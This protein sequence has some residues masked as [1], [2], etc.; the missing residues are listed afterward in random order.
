MRKIATAACALLVLAGA[1]G[2]QGSFGDTLRQARLQLDIGNPREAAELYERAVGMRSASAQ[3]LAPERAWAYVVLGNEALRGGDYS[4]AEAAYGMAAAVHEPFT[5]VFLRQWVYATLRRV[6]DEISRAVNDGAS[7][8]WESL[9]SSLKW[10]LRKVPSDRYA[11][12]TL[13]VLYDLTRRYDEARRHYGLLL[14]K[15]PGPD[16]ALEDLRRRARNRVSG[17]RHSFDMRPI[18]PPWRR[19]SSDLEP[20]RR[21]PFVIN[22]HNRDLAER[23][24][25]VMEY[26]LSRSALGGVLPANGP[27]PEVC[28]VFIFPDE[29]EFRESG[30]RE[31]WTGGRAKVF[32]Q[33]KRLVGAQIQL[34][35]TVPELTESA[36]PHELA[37]VR[38]LAV[39]PW[40][41]GLGLWLQEGV[42]TSQE[43]AYKKRSL[44]EALQRA[45]REGRLGTFREL[46]V[47]DEYPE[48]GPRDVFYGRCAAAVEMLV[49]RYGAESFREFIEATEHMD[50]E[51]ALKLVYGISPDLV[52]A[53]ILEWIES[54]I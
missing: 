50:Q 21:G 2:A 3:R 52:D 29:Q 11:D 44:A 30:G 27:F 26:H 28:N 51:Q 38:L 10:A 1:A 45:R 35:Q 32:V 24:A 15:D 36:V 48:N 49:E 14:E 47:L 43:S 7:A 33:D 40:V 17:L 9:E 41:D 12:Y 16:A 18:F 6:N 25:A 39:A 37:H 34:Y 4:R 8:D 54:R 31:I 22:H 53:L 19:A 23:V 42:A 13:A 20:L 5:D 46:M